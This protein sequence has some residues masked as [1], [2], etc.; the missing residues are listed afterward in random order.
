MALG[1]PLSNLVYTATGAAVE[2]L[3]VDG[4]VVC[5]RGQVDEGQEVVARA[6]EVAR[7]LFE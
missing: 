7:K 1:D 3:V 2:T 4:R 5:N 6:R